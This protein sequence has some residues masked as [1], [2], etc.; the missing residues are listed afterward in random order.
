M[1]NSRVTRGRATE[2]LVADWFRNAGVFPDAERRPAS[3]PGTDLF[4]TPGYSFEIKA[5]RAFDPQ[6]W[7]RQAKK[8][9][10]SGTIPV[11]VMRPDGVGEENVA[12]FL[13]FMTLDRFT[14]MVNRIQ[15]LEDANGFLKSEND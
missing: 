6:A 12:N 7:I 4:N 14:W 1:A 3:L 15:W 11:V 9:V 8:N 5:R 13:A 2:Q 10:T